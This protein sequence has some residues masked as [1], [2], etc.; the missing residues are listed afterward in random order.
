M[1]KCIL[2]KNYLKCKKLEKIKWEMCNLKKK[3]SAINWKFT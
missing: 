2:N 1:A 3:R